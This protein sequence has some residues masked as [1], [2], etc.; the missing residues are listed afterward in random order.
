M[1]S[2]TLWNEKTIVKA[3]SGKTP[4][5]R[6]TATCE[7]ERAGTDLRVKVNVDN[8][9]PQSGAY[10]DWRWAFSVYV[11]GV[12]VASNIEIK[13]RTY[14]NTFKGRHYTASSGWASINIGTASSANIEVRYF[15]TVA[16]NNN[17]IRS[18]MGSGSVT[19]GGIPPLPNVSISENNKS[20]SSI[21]INYSLSSQADYVRLWINNKE[22]GN[23]TSSP[24]TITGLNANT[25]YTISA[26]A[27]GNGAFGNQSNTLSITTYLVPSVVGSNEVKNIQPFSC[28]AYVSSSNTGNTSKYEFAL[29]NANKSVIKG[30]FTTNLS[31]YNFTGLN[32][33]TSYYIRYRVQS[34]DSGLW[35][36]YVY[37]PLFRTPADQ[38]QSYFKNGSSWTK[39]KMYFKINGQWKKVKKAYIKI[40]GQWILT[41]NK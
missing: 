41:K 18:N 2:V 5:V 21:I 22:Y 29:C 34:K 24:I 38:A 28:S 3:V 7:Y 23:Y 20:H 12:E 30:A 33:E 35:S 13:P 37:S 40:N 31:Y 10:W 4:E 17:K 9:C 32:E 36:D 11:N 14:L 6:S 15:D 26:K 19:L 16:S 27:Y 39:G 8:Y 1:A 25:T